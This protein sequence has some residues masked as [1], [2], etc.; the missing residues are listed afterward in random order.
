MANLLLAGALEPRVVA[1]TWVRRPSLY[2]GG[3]QRMR[4]NNLIST[5]DEATAKRVYDCQVDVYDAA[6]EA[7]L[8]TACP[9]GVPITIDGDL[10]G[11]SFT[12]TVDVAD[13]SV[14]AMEVETGEFLRVLALH[15]EEA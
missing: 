15:I 6:E 13:T 14:L 9:R 4:D 11:A 12:G 5:E 3:R 1:D 8:R 10:P 2:Q 7:A